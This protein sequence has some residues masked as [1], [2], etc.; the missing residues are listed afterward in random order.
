MSYYNNYTSKL[1]QLKKEE[2]ELNKYL[3]ENQNIDEAKQQQIRNDLI[4]LKAAQEE[5][6]SLMH[7]GFY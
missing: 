7:G 6:D 2:A 3:S 5:L 1:D 4:G